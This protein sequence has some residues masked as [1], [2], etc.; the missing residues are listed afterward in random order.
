LR[1]RQHYLV[2]K[3]VIQAGV[4]VLI[5]GKNAGIDVQS[6]VCTPP[7]QAIKITRFLKSAKINGLHNPDCTS[8]YASGVDTLGGNAH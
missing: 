1:Q 8:T 7:Y 3:I 5:K 4:D 6:K 2:M